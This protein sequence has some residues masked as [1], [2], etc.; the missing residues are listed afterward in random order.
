M[1]PILIHSNK[2]F[3][4]LIN[5]FKYARATKHICIRRQ[6]NDYVCVYVN[7]KR[8]FIWMKNKIIILGNIESE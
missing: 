4:L 7:F 3:F 5:V 2:V 8:V 1:M 6:E